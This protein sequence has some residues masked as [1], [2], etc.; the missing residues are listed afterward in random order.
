MLNRFY[1]LPAI[2]IVFGAQVLFGQANP[3]WASVFTRINQEVLANSKAYS[4]LK[5]ATSTIGHRLTGSENGQKAE[6]FAFDL[7]K[8]YG[9][10]KVRFQPFEVESWSRKTNS[11][12]IG[13]SPQELT[14]VKSVALAYS[15]VKADITEEIIDMGNGLETDYLANPGRVRNKIAFAYLGILEGSADDAVNLHRS[16]KTAL[17]IKYGAKGIILFNTADN[18]VLLTGT[19]SVTGKLIPIPAV[20]IGKE[21]GFALKNKLATGKQYAQVKMTNFSGLIKARNVIATL[22]GSTIPDEKIV[23]GGHLD[24]WDL[25]TG[26][27]DNGIGSFSVLDMARTFKALELKPQRTVE[28]VLFM[29][30]EEGLLGSKA[31]LKQAIKDNSV[32]QLRFMLNYDMTNDPTGYA[33]TTDESKA[34]FEGIGAIAKTIDTSFKNTFQSGAGLHSDHQP[35]MLEGIP[36]G[37]ASGGTLPN[38]SGRCY[39]ADCDDF[40]LVDEK[41]MQNTVR[42]NTMLLYG[43]A[44]AAVIAAKRLDDTATKEL[45]LKSN[46]KEPLKIAGEWRWKD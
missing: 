5:T 6:Q 32:K 16:E 21:D 38:N 35:F 23:V 19:A 33:A 37:G 27:I 29:G 3:E 15:P 41:G 2:Y 25:A 42:F 9:F 14:A 11:V 24:S 13:S 44:D 20:C 46:L 1:I 10:T 36:T 26:A 31:Y 40:A 12:S 28:F 8:S 17:A 4:S 34:L 22:P 7:L 30:E 39:H 45:M 43:L 18:G